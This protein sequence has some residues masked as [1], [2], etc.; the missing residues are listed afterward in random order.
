[1]IVI[2]DY[3]PAWPRLFDAEAARILAAFGPDALR[4]E[5]VGSTAVPGLAAKPVIDI[6]VSVA[7]LLPHGRYVQTMANLGYRHQPWDDFDLVYPFFHRPH[8]W[9]STHHVHLCEAGSPLEGK[10]LAF[11]DFL[12]S[13][14]ET[15]DAYQRL[16]RA[17]ALEHR[18]E[19]LQTREDYS[20]SKSE[21]IDDVLRAAAAER[22]PAP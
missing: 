5:H 8:E 2:C 14:P 9:P 22:K 12:R 11:R 20:L 15:A 17:L 19:S 10:H 4:I 7:T 18:G 6:Q 3:D 16:K 1:M 13:H 21:F